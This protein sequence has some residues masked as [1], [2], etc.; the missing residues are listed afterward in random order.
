MT[1]N[2]PSTTNSAENDT[3]GA[4]TPVVAFFFSF[5]GEGPTFGGTEA[6]RTPNGGDLQK[7]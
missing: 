3:K 7:K 1:T 2:P 5:F 4:A 6:K